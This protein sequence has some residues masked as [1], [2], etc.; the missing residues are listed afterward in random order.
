MQG[1]QLSVQTQTTEMNWIHNL[2]K[3][4]AGKMLVVSMEDVKHR[5]RSVLTEFTYSS[6]A[7]QTIY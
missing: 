4:K 6:F 2:G 7:G 1:L 5:W 3:D